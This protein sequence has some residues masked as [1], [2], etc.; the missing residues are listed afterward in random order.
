MQLVYFKAQPD[1]L[2]KLY[3][4]GARL[5]VSGRVEWYDMRPQIPHPDYVLPVERAGEMPAVEPVYGLTAGL[6]P[7]VLRRAIGEALKR[8][9]DLPEWLSPDLARGARL[10][11]LR[12]RAS[13]GARAGRAGGR[14]PDR[15]RPGSGSPSTS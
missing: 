3:P 14:R 8:L 9:P 5:V 11:R 2:K 1:W 7:K 12:R 4:I 13:T 10:A 6:S 15:A